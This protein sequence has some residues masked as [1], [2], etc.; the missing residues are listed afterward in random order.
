LAALLDRNDDIEV[1]IAA[2][3]LVVVLESRRPAMGRG[4]WNARGH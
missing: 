4:N 3:R 2:A 1:L